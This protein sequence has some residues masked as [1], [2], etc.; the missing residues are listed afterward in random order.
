MGKGLQSGG[1]QLPSLA[2]VLMELHS[3]PRAPTL[4]LLFFPHVGCT[5]FCCSRGCS[6]CAGPP[7]FGEEGMHDFI[8]ER[9]M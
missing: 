2:C 1:K 3:L 6:L 5:L 7:P 9:Y 8:H 4:D